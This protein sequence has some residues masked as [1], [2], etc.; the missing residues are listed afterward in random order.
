MAPWSPDGQQLGWGRITCRAGLGEPRPLCSALQV[1]PTC[2]QD[3]GLPSRCELTVQ[4][5]ILSQLQPISVVSQKLP[6]VSQ[7][8]QHSR[9]S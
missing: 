9:K 4:P 3:G 1:T 6:V 2:S 8:R 7:G 5:S